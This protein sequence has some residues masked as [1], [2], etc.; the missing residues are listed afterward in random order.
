MGSGIGHCS[1]DVRTVEVSARHRARDLYVVDPGAGSVGSGVPVGAARRL[2][3]RASREADDTKN[4]CQ[5]PRQPEAGLICAHLGATAPRSCRRSPERPPFAR[6]R[7]SLK[8]D[9]NH[10]GSKFGQKST[11]CGDSV[12]QPG[13]PPLHLDL[14]A[15]DDGASPDRGSDCGSDERSDSGACGGDSGLQIVEVAAALVA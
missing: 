10:V 7:F 3:P 1:G 8:F 9:V 12:D 4:V 15:V 6:R 14:P 11:T 5:I 13:P 2:A